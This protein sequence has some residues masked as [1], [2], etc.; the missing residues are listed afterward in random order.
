MNNLFAFHGIDHK[1]GVTMVAQSVAEL[2]ASQNSNI[3]VLFVSLNARKNCEYVKEEVKTID[4]FKLQ[5][6][7]Q[8]LI[9]KDFVRECRHKGNLYILA[10]LSNEQE[11]RYYFPDSAKYLLE[12]VESSFEIIIADTGSELDNGLALG[13]MLIAA[14]NYLVLTQLES[15]LCRYENRAPW[16][17]K[18]EVKFGGLIVNKF[19]KDDPHTLKYIIERLYYDKEKT[20]RVQAAGYDRQAELEHKTLMEFKTDSYLEHIT[21]IANDVLE[22]AALPQIELQRKNKLWKSFI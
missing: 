10:G 12:S 14:K 17:E 15:N 1:V 18:A 13:G 11:E 5:L 19:Y 22:R 2:I 6:D 21:I 3:N 7:S 9:C 16:F 8:M 20:F 4:E